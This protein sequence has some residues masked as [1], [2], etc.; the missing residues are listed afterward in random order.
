[1]LVLVLLAI[2]VITRRSF[3]I[4]CEP[5]KKYLTRVYIV[6][7]WFRTAFS[8]RPYLHFFHKSDSR[9]FHSHRWEWSYGLVLWGGYREERVTNDCGYAKRTGQPCSYHLCVANRL[10]ETKTYRPF[11]INRLDSDCFHRVDLLNEKRG[12]LTLFLAGPFAK[13]D[14]GFLRDDGTV[15]YASERFAGKRDSLSD[16]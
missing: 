11:F 1:M 8:C 13:D 9:E 15:E 10:V 12:C 7:R 2:Y 3:T 16:D 6:G 5:A 4:W 14:W